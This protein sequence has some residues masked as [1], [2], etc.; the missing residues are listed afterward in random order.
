MFTSLF[1]KDESHPP[2]CLLKALVQS[3]ILQNVNKMSVEVR[4]RTAYN[5]IMQN[6]SR[7]RVVKVFVSLLSIFTLDVAVIKR[8]LIDLV[9]NGID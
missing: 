5:I 3:Y 7:T 9:L 4:S 6:V 8:S 2:K 1:L